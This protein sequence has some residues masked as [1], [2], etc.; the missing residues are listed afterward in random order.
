M[1]HIVPNMMKI[2]IKVLS[3]MIAVLFI[4]DLTT[5]I[6]SSIHIILVFIFSYFTSATFHILVKLF[7]M[8]SHL[9]SAELIIFPT[10]DLNNR[11]ERMQRETIYVSFKKKAKIEQ[12]K[13]RQRAEETRFD[14]RHGKVYFTSLLLPDLF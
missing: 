12:R 2:Y 10:H 8:F 14:S 11:F 5:I 9:H 13:L 3:F 7:K 4:L 6:C 1:V